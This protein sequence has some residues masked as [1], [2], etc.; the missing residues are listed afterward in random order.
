MSGS[1]E[2]GEQDN[3]APYLKHFGETPEEQLQ[4]NQP[5]MEWLKKQME[6]A[7]VLS[8]EEININRQLLDR[9]K[10]HIDSFRPEGHKLFSE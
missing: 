3:I 5:L 1:A 7:E 10:T 8:E 4:K 9:L 2:L 6:K